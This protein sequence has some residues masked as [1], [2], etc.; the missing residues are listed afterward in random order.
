M[1]ITSFKK[2]MKLK[3]KHYRCSR[4]LAIAVQSSDPE[5]YDAA[6]EAWNKFI[7][8]ARKNTDA[9]AKKY[10]AEA[11]KLVKELDDARVMSND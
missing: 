10:I 4:K 8:V 1:A 3:P 6:I 9:R 7:A 2:A 11:E 5:N